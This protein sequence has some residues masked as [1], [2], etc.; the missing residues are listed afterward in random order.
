M[1]TLQALVTWTPFLLGGFLWNILI[2]ALAMVLG[3]AVGS[4]LAWLRLSPRS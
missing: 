3:T 4:C 1:N 2:A